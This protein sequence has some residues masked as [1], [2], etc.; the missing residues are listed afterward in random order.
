MAELD[1]ST[2]LKRLLAQNKLVLG[3]DETMKL[4]RQKKVQR[5][6]LTANVDPKVREDVERL[7]KLAGVECQNIVQRND[8]VGAICKKPFA[9]SVVAVV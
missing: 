1:T 3:T 8:E 6:L 7:C 4:L 5:V 2:D 9:I